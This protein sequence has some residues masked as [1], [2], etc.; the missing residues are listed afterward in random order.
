MHIGCKQAGRVRLTCLGPFG[1]WKIIQPRQKSSPGAMN[2]ERWARIFGV[3]GW[4][5]PLQLRYMQPARL[6]LLALWATIALSAET[7]HLHSIGGTHNTHNTLGW[8]TV[9]ALLKLCSALPYQYHDV[10]LGTKVRGR[11]AHGELVTQ[12]LVETDSSAQVG[13]HDDTYKKTV[14]QHTY[15]GGLQP[16]REVESFLCCADDGAPP[17]RTLGMA[18]HVT[19]PLAWIYTFARMSRRRRRQEK[20]PERAARRLPGSAGASNFALDCDESPGPAT[21]STGFRAK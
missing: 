3:V 11:A 8:V 12:M 18:G 17:Y 20:K 2:L 6:C 14:L 19:S 1:G 21:V 7:N 10:L 5:V 13:G 16:R 9:R 15:V 4:N